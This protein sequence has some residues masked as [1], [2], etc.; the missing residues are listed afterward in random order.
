M[1]LGCQTSFPQEPTDREIIGMKCW[2]ETKQ[3]KL[4]SAAD[5]LPYW[6]LN[7]SLGKEKP[8]KETC[9]ETNSVG[10]SERKMCQV[11]NSVYRDKGCVI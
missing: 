2:G 6:V 11:T 3:M 9:L 10:D 5:P 4:M 8:G 1:V 7:G